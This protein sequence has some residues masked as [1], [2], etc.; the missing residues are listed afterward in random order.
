MISFSLTRM[1]KDRIYQ[2]FVENDTFHGLGLPKVSLPRN[3]ID[4]LIECFWM[5]TIGIP[6]LIW[7][8]NFLVIGSWSAKLIFAGVLFVA[9]GI[10]QRMINMSVIKA[11]SKT[12]KR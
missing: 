4:L 11:D 7:L 12:K 8:V 9:Y 5:V 10:L 6:S 1:F 2:H 3:N